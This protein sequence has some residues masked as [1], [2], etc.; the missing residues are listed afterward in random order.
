M[1]NPTVAHEAPEFNPVPHL[2]RVRVSLLSAISAKIAEMTAA[3]Q[4]SET[5]GLTIAKVAALLEFSE[6]QLAAL[7]SCSAEGLDL[8]DLFEAA[9]LVG[10]NVDV[11]I[12]DR[13]QA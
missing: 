11:V 8:T 13:K 7:V 2:M 10:L 3:P 1:T 9:D 4:S 6:S 12:S 5:A